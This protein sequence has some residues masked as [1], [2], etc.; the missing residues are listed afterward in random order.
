MAL[1]T[2]KYKEQLKNV[3]S[4]YMDDVAQMELAVIALIDSVVEDAYEDGYFDS[5]VEERNKEF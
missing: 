1:D 2:K 3:L 4:S 5:Y